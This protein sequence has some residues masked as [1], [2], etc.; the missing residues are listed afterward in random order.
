MKWIKYIILILILGFLIINID[1]ITDKVSDILSSNPKVVISEP[2]KYYRDKS[3]NYVKLSKDYVPYSKQDLLDIFYSILNSGYNTFTFYCPSEYTECLKDVENLSDNQDTLTNINNFVNSFNSFSN[4][5]IIYSTSGEVNIEVNKLYTDDEI[6]SINKRMDEIEKDLYKDDMNA[7]DKI[8]AVH[9]Y[10]I[11]N[12]KYD[13]LRAKG[14]SPYKS[15]KAYG[16]LIEG[17]AVCGGYA[18]A[19]ELFL[20]RL[21]V[22]N[23]KISSNTHV[24]NAVYI[25]DKWLHL[26]LTWDDPVTLNSDKDTLTHK[27]YLID[28]PSLEEY[29]ISDHDFDKTIYQELS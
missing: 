10:I 28:T 29:K 2:N 22:T 26:D 14:E 20:D 15:N 18:D 23:Y 6:V 16:S 8:L 24:W 3:F 5:K 21:N 9:D 25:N 4:I 12:T 1:S 13:E 7:E 11:N 19:M 17:Y 27:F